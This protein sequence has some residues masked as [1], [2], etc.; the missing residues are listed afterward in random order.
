MVMFGLNALQIQEQSDGKVSLLIG[1]TRFKAISILLILTWFPFPIWFAL[2]PE[3]F[4]LIEDAL[5][6]HAGWAFLNIVSKFSFIFYIQRIKDNYCNRLKAKREM[7][8]LQSVDAN[9][10]NFSQGGQSNMTPQQIKEM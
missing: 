10:N 6:I 7:Y 2:S 4:G 8:G 9:E 1:N 3:G 5:L